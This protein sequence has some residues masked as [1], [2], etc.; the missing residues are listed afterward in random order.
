MS[1]YYEAHFLCPYIG[2]YAVE[3]LHSLN[4]QMTQLL[5][6]LLVNRILDLEG[7]IQFQLSFISPCPRMTYVARAPAG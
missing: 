6:H 4:L 2:P 5:K 1:R 3:M 7:L